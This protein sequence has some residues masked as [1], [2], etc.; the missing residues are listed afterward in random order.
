M[1]EM[2]DSIEAQLVKHFFRT[3]NADAITVLAIALLSTDA[4]DADTGV[5]T[6]GT[7]V[8]VL[9]AGGYE[10]ANDANTGG[11]ASNTTNPLDANWT[12][13]AAGDGQTDNI[14]AIT[15]ATATA[16]WASAA[17]I[18]GIGICSSA[19][20]NAGALY[21]HTPVAIPK[22]VLQDDTAVFEIGTITITFD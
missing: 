15:W 13:V 11:G 8:E 5:F 2:S 18:T 22:P 20:H 7:G 10:R 1:S 17:N 14:A 21:F 6:S 9:S 4:I 16:D 3:G 12:D 19:T